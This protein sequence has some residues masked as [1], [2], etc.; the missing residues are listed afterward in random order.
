MRLTIF[1]NALHF[2][3]KCS[4][5]RRQSQFRAKGACNFS[6]SHVYMRKTL[7][8]TCTPAQSPPPQHLQHLDFF[9]SN[10]SHY[11]KSLKICPALFQISPS[12]SK[13]NFPNFTFSQKFF[14]FS[15]AKT[16][17]SNFWK[18]WIPLL[19]QIFLWFCKIYVFFYIGHTLDFSFPPSLTMMHL[20][21]RCIYASHNARTGRPWEAFPSSFL[22]TPSSKIDRAWYN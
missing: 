3:M 4:K 6:D 13:E 2:G 21:I 8:F 11:L 20:C 18:I 9:T 22:Y 17:P 1:Q 19:L 16:F 5:L 15:S 12:I 7:K 14:R 10:M